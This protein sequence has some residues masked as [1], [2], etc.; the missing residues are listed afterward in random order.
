M[1]KELISFCPNIES[2]RTELTNR[3]FIDEDGE[4]LFPLTNR[5]PIQKKFYP[6]TTTSVLCLSGVDIELLTSFECIEVLGTKEEV[7]ADPDK[8]AKYVSAYSRDSYTITDPET[9]E[10]ITITP[11]YWHGGF[12]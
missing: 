9:N 11:S 8:T 2:L 10:G 4:P 6:K 12:A 5:T 3:G 7:D 1:Y